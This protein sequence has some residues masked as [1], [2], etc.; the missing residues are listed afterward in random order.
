VIKD[1]KKSDELP[2]SMYRV[3]EAHVLE[4]QDRRGWGSEGFVNGRERSVETEL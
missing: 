2:L 1:V 4:G 3:A